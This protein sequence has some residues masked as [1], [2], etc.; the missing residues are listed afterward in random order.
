[1]E[2][3][4]K[5][6]LPLITDS[7]FQMLRCVIV[8]AHADNIV[9]ES[10]RAFLRTLVAH[11]QRGLTLTAAHMARLEEDLRVPQDIENL[12]PGVVDRSDR[13]QL[14]LFAGLLAQADG[15]MHP[16][17]EAVL[18]KIKAHNAAATGS[19]FL[20]A[21]PKPPAFATVFEPPSQIAVQLPTPS[22]ALEV[23]PPPAGVQSFTD[24]VREIIRQEIYRQNLTTS[25]VTR[26]MRPAAVVDAFAEKSVIVPTK[27]AREILTDMPP[28]SHGM[29]RS[30][31]PG[32]RLA[33][34][35]AFHW[36]YVLD[37]VLFGFLLWWLAPYAGKA[38]VR[39]AQWLLDSPKF[40]E[41][42]GRHQA[43]VIYY[44]SGKW[45]ALAPAIVCYVIAVWYLVWKLL[46]WKTT[47]ILITDK[48]IL[49]KQ[50]I[51]SIR[52]HKLDLEEVG[53]TTVQQSIFGK[54]LDYGAIEAFTNYIS[55]DTG[56]RMKLPPIA[57]PHGFATLI[58]RAQRMWVMGQGGNV[59][60]VRPVRQ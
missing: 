59:T 57:D 43:Q 52:R 38:G 27:D 26:G 9:K 51:L 24:E 32:E 48:R 25:G 28:L 31:V 7:T 16:N 11:I 53:K 42:A 17:E 13:E 19:S 4:A 39:G 30:L 34:K 41:M 60:N 2:N 18:R 55:G 3:Q 20:R 6:F 5:T 46:V 49:I 33:G 44:L 12:L 58:D 40:L 8:V 35:A 50:G 14:V 36:V 47:E 23:M 29:K 56:G 45:A 21:G 22:S 1:M 54:L 10:E 37:A 15:E